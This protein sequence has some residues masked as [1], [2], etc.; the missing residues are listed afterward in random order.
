MTDSKPQAANISAEE[1]RKLLCIP[2][3]GI[4]DINCKQ[5]K[6]VRRV[7]NKKDNLCYDSTF[8]PADRFQ[9]FKAGEQA[10]GQCLFYSKKKLLKKEKAADAEQ[11]EVDVEKVISSA[12]FDP[13][14]DHPLLH[15]RR[16]I[17]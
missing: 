14:R 8:I 13:W 11:A 10:R 3:R 1:R 15:C 12:L 7:Y 6:L 9:D 17:S 16:A 5:L 4:F 2:P